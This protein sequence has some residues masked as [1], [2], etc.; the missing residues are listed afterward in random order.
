MTILH[1][2]KQHA[3]AFCIAFCKHF[4]RVLQNAQ[5]TSGVGL[6]PFFR[7]FCHFAQNFLK[8]I[9]RDKNTKQTHNIYI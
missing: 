6:R 9:N 2:M 7:A 3:R 1:S 5:A 4:A 8:H